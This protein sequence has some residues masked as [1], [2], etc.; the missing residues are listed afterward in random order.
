M[1]SKI[2]QLKVGVI[3]SYI[4]RIITVVVGLIYT[5][6]MIRLLGQN[7]YGLYN[8]AASTISYLG[9]L[10]FGFGSA[11]MRFYSRY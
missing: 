10:N 9:I 6:I 1:K 7:E 3:L 8:I 2:N 5:P 11:Y 4:S